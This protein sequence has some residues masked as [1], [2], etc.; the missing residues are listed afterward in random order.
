MKFQQFVYKNTPS[1]Q[2]L[3][4]YTDRHEFVFQSKIM[5]DLLH[6]D[7]KGK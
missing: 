5:Y 2:H 4:I 6:S 1:S 3:E 7:G